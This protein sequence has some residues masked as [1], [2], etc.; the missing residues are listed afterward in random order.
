MEEDAIT[1]ES[2]V[3]SSLSCIG[4]RRKYD[5]DSNARAQLWCGILYVGEEVLIVTTVVGFWA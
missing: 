3:T 4:V 5:M 1:A 2:D